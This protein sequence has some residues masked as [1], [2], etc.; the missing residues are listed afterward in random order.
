MTSSPRFDSVASELTVSVLGHP[1]GARE[2]TSMHTVGA[3]RFFARIN[4]EQD[5]DGLAPVRAIGFRIKQAH[6]ELHMSQVV[7]C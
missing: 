2:M 7:N 1:V 4:S 5:G 6:V 3:L